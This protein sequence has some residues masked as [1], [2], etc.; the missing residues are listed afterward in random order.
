LLQERIRN[1]SIFSLQKIFEVSAISSI[2]INW[3]HA[4]DKDNLSNLTKESLAKREI[5]KFLMSKWFKMSK[6]IDNNAVLK[7]NI[8]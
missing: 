5:S 2:Y 7:N 6:M 4:H 1:A 3:T 8:I